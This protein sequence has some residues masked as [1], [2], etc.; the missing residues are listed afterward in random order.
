MQGTKLAESGKF[1]QIRRFSGGVNNQQGMR[2]S[3]DEMKRRREKE[4]AET[5]LH[6]ICWG[7]K[8]QAFFP[9]KAS[10]FAR[11]LPIV[12][13]SSSTLQ[14]EVSVINLNKIVDGEGT[15]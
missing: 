6:L 7:L 2:D 3:S 1:N 12:R 8:L 13:H 9:L 4:K 15:V 10:N 5:L 14:F 11:T